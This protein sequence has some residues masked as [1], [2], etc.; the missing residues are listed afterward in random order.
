MYTSRNHK[1]SLK[2]TST[3]KL[4]YNCKIV[5]Y[6]TGKI[7]AGF[8]AVSP[9]NGIILPNCEE[10]FTIKFSPT[11]VE[12]FLR[13]LLSISIKNLDPS[14]EKLILELDGEVERPICHFE[15]SP[16]KYR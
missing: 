15:L 1:I 5:D 12:D 16:T 2:N 4:Q 10:T 7:D 3:I 14:Q 11:E 9:H 13:R 8:F 6:E